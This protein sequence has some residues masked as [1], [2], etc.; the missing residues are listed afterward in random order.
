MIVLKIEKINEYNN[1]FLKDNS[2]NKNYSL[3]LEFYGVEKPV[4]GSEIAIN[5]KLLNPNYEGFAQPYAFEL[6][7]DLTSLDKNNAE[8]IALNIKNKKYVLKRI[9]G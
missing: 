5:E 2:S 7:K 4:V 9:Y 8:Y 3:Y 1:Y 6:C